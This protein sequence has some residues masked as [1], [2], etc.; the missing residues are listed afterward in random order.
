MCLVSR[1]EFVEAYVNH[2]F[3]SSVDGVFEEFR[4][5][6][7]QACDRHVVELF[8]PEELRGLMAGQE[9]NDWARFKQVCKK[10]CIKH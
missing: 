10:T 1:R 9:F 3:N 7:F 8:T 2:V 4:R 5:G 6:F